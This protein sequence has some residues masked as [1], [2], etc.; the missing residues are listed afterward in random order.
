MY[1]YDGK[2]VE[3]LPQRASEDF[4]LVLIDYSKDTCDHFIR[5]EM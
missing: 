1:L 2:T 3:Q 5:I 4:A